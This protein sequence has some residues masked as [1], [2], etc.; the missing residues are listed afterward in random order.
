MSINENFVKI[1]ENKVVCMWK[2]KKKW[3]KWFPA[4]KLKKKKNEKKRKKKGGKNFSKKNFQ[5]FIFSSTIYDEDTQHFW[6]L[7]IFRRVKGQKT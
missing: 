3:V 4:K 2:F 6:T 5:K 7:L 1:N